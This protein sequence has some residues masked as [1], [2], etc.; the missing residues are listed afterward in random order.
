M[1]LPFFFA[2]LDCLKK[3]G[4]LPTTSSHNYREQSQM[5]RDR[6]DEFCKIKN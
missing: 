5:D 2:E 6:S 4:L 3:D 1:F